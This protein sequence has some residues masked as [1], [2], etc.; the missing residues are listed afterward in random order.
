MNNTLVK[1]DHKYIKVDPQKGTYIK[2]T[3][4]RVKNIIIHYK[5]GMSVEEI[6][7]GFPNITPAQFYDALSYYY[8]YKE[9]IEKE[10]RAEDLREIEKEFNL[11]LQLNG[12]LRVQ[13]E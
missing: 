6:L 5:S 9:E 11:K 10:I 7:E 2:D 4:V 13:N 12:T 8:D 3:R 1:T